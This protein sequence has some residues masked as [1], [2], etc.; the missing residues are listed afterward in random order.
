MGLHPPLSAGP[1]DGWP[2]ESGTGRAPAA[3]AERDRCR[4]TAGH[5]YVLVCIGFLSSPLVA[6]FGPGPEGAAVPRWGAQLD[7]DISFYA[8]LAADFVHGPE[9]AVEGRSA[10]RGVCSLRRLRLPPTSGLGRLARR[11]RHRGEQLDGELLSMPLAADFGPG[12]EAAAEGRSAGWG[13]CFLRLSPPTSGL[14]RRRRRRGAE[15]HGEFAH[16]VSRRRLRA[17][18][19]GGSGG[20]RSWTVSLDG[21]FAHNAFRRRIRAWPGG[22]GGRALSLTGN[23]LATPLAAEFGPGPEAAEKRCAACREFALYASRR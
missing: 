22:G 23:S 2:C 10:G 14:A 17:W 1:A 6:N 19:G 5:K 13:V 11:G 9:E 16:Y 15:L 18:P 7:G 12:P 20:E 3:T 21:K 4:T 8:P